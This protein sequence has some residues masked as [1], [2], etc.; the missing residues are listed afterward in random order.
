MI[1][2]TELVI[3]VFNHMMNVLSLQHQECVATLEGTPTLFLARA[4]PPPP[5]ENKKCCSYGAARKLACFASCTHSLHGGQDDTTYIE[6][7]SNHTQSSPKVNHV[8]PPLNLS[9]LEPLFHPCIHEHCFDDRT[10]NNYV[11]L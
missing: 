2:Y 8:R 3:L 6:C 1:K 7:R 11:P 4:A 10:S 9:M 5:L